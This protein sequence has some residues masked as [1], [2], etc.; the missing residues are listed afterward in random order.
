ML[1]LQFTH[2]KSL[3]EQFVSRLAALCCLGLSRCVCVCVCVCVRVRACVCVCV[4]VCV[5]QHVAD[6]AGVL[7]SSFL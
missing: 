1:H 5:F 4:C 2:K 3:I 6:V 7:S